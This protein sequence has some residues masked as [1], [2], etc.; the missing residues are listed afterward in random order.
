MPRHR[1]GTKPPLFW[2]TTSDAVRWERMETEGQILAGKYRLERFLGSGGFA[3]VWAARNIELDRAVALK[4]LAD[5]FARIPGAVERFSREARIASRYI[6]PTICRV[7]DVCRTDADVPF[8]VMELLEGSTLDELLSESGALGL[9][10]ALSVARLVIEG[11]AAAHDLGIIHRDVKPA[12]IFLVREG[13]P[14]PRVRILDLGLAKDIA[15]DGSLTRTGQLM[16]TPDFLAPEILLTS[17]RE[18]WT[19]AVDVFAAGMLLYCMLTGRLPFEKRSSGP[20]EARLADRILA[21]SKGIPIRPPR[22][23]APSIPAE[24][25]AFVQRS[26]ALVPADRL[27]NAGEMLQALDQATADCG[28]SHGS[29][30]PVS[31]PGPLPSGVAAT[32]AIP[33]ASDSTGPTPFT[34]GT[35]PPVERRDPPPARGIKIGAAVGAALLVVSALVTGA[36]FWFQADAGD[37]GGSSAAVRP[38]KALPPAPPPADPTPPIERG[39]AAPPTTVADAGSVEAGPARVKVRLLGLPRR[40]RVTFRDQPVEGEWIEGA[41]GCAGRLEIQAPRYEPYRKNLVLEPNLELD[42]RAEL[43]RRAR[44]PG[45]QARA[46]TKAGRPQPGR[47][48]PNHTPGQVSK[49]PDDGYIQGAR[50]TKIKTYYPPRRSRD[51]E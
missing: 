41:E 31:Q 30:S 8:L 38:A 1:W 27:S 3:S 20:L 46:S 25:D 32:P 50:N 43:H 19:P 14:G 49:T 11:L 2:R 37:E 5:N 24:I 39:D 51:D 47:A 18:A 33:T 44:R 26:L 29:L 7:E 9:T 48:T 21:Y 34:W 36:V 28:L 17:S 16:G 13:F 23:Y 45:D 40:A 10:E 15:D 6:H 4:I 22:D 42:L 35:E 12:N